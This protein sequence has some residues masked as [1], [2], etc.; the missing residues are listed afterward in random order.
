M[1]TSAG[2]QSSADLPGSLLKS[3]PSAYS[4]RPRRLSEDSRFVQRPQ[5]AIRR[6]AAQS[7]IG[8]L[9]AGPAPWWFARP[10]P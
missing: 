10:R 4:L 9:W 1:A 7:G 6:A 2:R 3:A 5:D 8:G